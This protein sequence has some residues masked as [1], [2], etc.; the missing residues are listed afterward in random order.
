MLQTFLS[1]EVWG[2]QFCLILL[3]WYFPPVCIGCFGA[4]Y[5]ALNTIQVSPPQ[6]EEATLPVPDSASLSFSKGPG[7]NVAMTTLK[8]L[9]TECVLIEQRYKRS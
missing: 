9:A 8:L 5:S 2:H 4:F 6:S 7:H 3:F 1:W